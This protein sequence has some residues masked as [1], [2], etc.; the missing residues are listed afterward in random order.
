MKL[1][2]RTHRSSAKRGFTLVE[3]IGVLAIIAVLAVVIAPKVFSAI[4]SSRINGTLVSIDAYKTAAA[5]FVGKYGTLPVTTANNRLDDLFIAAGLIDERFSAKI[6]LQA[7]V[8]ATAGGTWARGATGVWA[9][10]G[11]SS[12]ASLSRIISLNRNANPPNTANGANYRLNGTTDMPTG[13]RIVSAVLESVPEAEARELSERIDGQALSTAAGADALGKVV[14][15]A[16][17][18]GVTDV[19]IYMMHQ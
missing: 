8:Y 15:N 19:Y 16:P 18:G 4:R 14:Y 3:M 17:T 10:T 13:A 11:G 6:G 12:Q 7:D 1:M 5:E 2:N 9:P